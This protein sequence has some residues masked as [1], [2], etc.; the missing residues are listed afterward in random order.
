MV[1]TH[2]HAH[3]HHH[4]HAEAAQPTM[5]LLRMSALTRLAGAGA[6]LVLLWIA[7]L[8]VLD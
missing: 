4:H 7:V 5:S 8:S 2:S 6:V 3:R 1:M